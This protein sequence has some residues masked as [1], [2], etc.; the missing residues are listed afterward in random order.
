MLPRVSSPAMT[1]T[2]E[3]VSLFARRGFF[4]EGS[5]RLGCQV[6]QIALNLDGHRIFAFVL[7]FLMS[8]MLSVALTCAITKRRKRESLFKR[9]ASR[10]SVLQGSTRIRATASL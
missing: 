10:G 8:S 5:I 6:V 4:L 3:W 9:L 2:V 1:L 7:I